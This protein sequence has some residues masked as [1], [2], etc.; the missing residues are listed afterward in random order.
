MDLFIP[1][2]QPKVR[3]AIPHAA[4]N[5]DYQSICSQINCGLAVGN[6]QFLGQAP[7][8][9]VKPDSCYYQ[10]C[11]ASGVLSLSCRLD[12]LSVGAVLRGN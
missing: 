3:S 1:Y 8:I 10:R 9:P 5:T 4:C 11:A 6:S 12:F 7:S 2:R